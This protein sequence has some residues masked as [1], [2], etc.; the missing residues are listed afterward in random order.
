MTNK[1]MGKVRLNYKDNLTRLVL[2]RA[3]PESK[4]LRLGDT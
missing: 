2:K 1:L 3:L 4:N